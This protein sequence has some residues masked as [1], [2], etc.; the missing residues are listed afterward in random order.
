MKW[1]SL[2][3]AT[4]MSHYEELTASFIF[5]LRTFSAAMLALYVSY[6]FDLSQPV[7]AFMTVY[8]VSAPFLGMVRS[9]AVY[10]ILGTFTGAVFCVATIPNLVDAPEILVLTIACW[11][12]G[13]LYLSIIDGTPRSYAFMLA[14]YTTALIGFPSVNAPQ[15]MFDIALSRTEEIGLG[16]L[17]VQLMSYL[18]FQQHAGDALLAR[19]DKWLKD[20]RLWVTDLLTYAREDILV[21]DRS[22]LMIDAANLDALRIHASY[23]TPNF[24]N[25]EGW[26]VRLQ[27]HIQDVFADLVTLEAQIKALKQNDQQSLAQMH[28][29]IDAILAWI[30]SGEDAVPESVTGTLERA[31]DNPAMYG[32]IKSGAIDTASSLVTRHA[33][34]MDLR[35]KI[36]AGVKVEPDHMPLTR[37]VDHRQAAIYGLFVAGLLCLISSFWILS[38]WPEG[39]FAAMF[40]T[41][42]VCFFASL[43]APPKIAFLALALF[44]IG[45]LIGWCYNFVVFPHIDGFPLLAYTLG[46]ICIP[47]GL[48]MAKP[49]LTAGM[50][51]VIQ[52]VALASMQNRFS[53][54]ITVF[55][56]NFV[57]QAIGVTAAGATLGLIRAISLRDAT[58]RLLQENDK[59]LGALAS[60]TGSDNVIIDQMAHRAGMAFIRT[61]GLKN[62]RDKVVARILLDLQAAR[63]L[64]QIKT[65][66]PSV[67][68]EI[69]QAL[70][71][72]QEQVVIYVSRR[73]S[74][75]EPPPAVCDDMRTL[76]HKMNQHAQ[77]YNT[78][79]LIG[80]MKNLSR[81][82]GMEAE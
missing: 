35:A 1:R 61:P 22:R 23:D 66:L 72:V 59:S 74:F 37:Y 31:T 11:I 20:A 13:C 32:L 65:I 24:N 52:G 12:A 48:I 53:A 69:Q 2:M 46:L 19:I 4:A 64:A 6:L 63:A 17:C 9:K 5:S 76:M 10:R 50:L 67:P 51:P 29:I 60:G 71:A 78:M 62:A 8:I 54:D 33:E 49:E 3:Q 16:I 77:S 81:G 28:S 27:R 45:A 7:W 36:N 43:E 38:S 55:L 82:L 42:I 79:R 58:Q 47:I 18:P 14:G 39:H 44:C 70:C 15:N 34:C 26:I 80:L 75:I 25:I 30:R 40:A 41:I 56:N 57:A 21:A 68:A 73:Q